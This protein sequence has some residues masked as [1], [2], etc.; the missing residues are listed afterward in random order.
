M[1]P[2]TPAPAADEQTPAPQ[3]DY[4]GRSKQELVDTLAELLQQRPVQALRGEVE[5][6]KVAFYKLHRAEAERA[7]HAFVEAGGAPEEFTPEPDAQETRLKELLADYRKR[8]DEFAATAEQQKEEHLKLKLAIIEE[9]KT[10]IDSHETIGQTWGAFRELQQRWRAVG[11]VP[12]AQNKDLW[13]TYNHH[14]ENFYNLVKIDRE[15]RDLDLRRNYEAKIA[16]CEQ[17]E[18]LLL[19]ASIV[20]AFNKLQKLHEQWREV[21]PVAVEFK[22]TLWERFK[23]ASARVNRR[24]QEHFEQLKGEQK[25]NL[26]LKTQLCVELDELA[27]SPPDTRV[28]WEK[29]SERLL[30]IQQLWKTIGFAPRKENT[31]I[32]E[33]FRAACDKFF[34]QKRR[35]YAEQ[36]GEMD[37]NLALKQQLCIQAEALRESDDW[38]AASDELIA[39][40]KQWK[41]I[42]PVPRRHSD[43]IWKRF[44]AACDAF[45]E[46]KAAHFSVQDGAHAE[47]LRLKEALLAEI[48]AFDGALT[49]D[50][51][52]EFQRRWS[53]IGFVPIKQKDALQAHYK[54][55]MDAMFDQL[56]GAQGERRMD[57]FRE[58]VSTLKSSGGTRLN[59][60]RSRLQAHLKQTEAE[61]QLLEN[62]IGF[63]AKSKNAEAMIREVRAKIER[64]KGEMAAT[65]EKIKL[66]E[67]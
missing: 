2:Q 15:L 8:R 64:A 26:D 14:V 12:L 32:Y 20:A 65:I 63:F 39:L 56:R 11:P 10:L 50:A 36:R 3:N 57:R 60:E 54:Q 62:N 16:L 7:R 66:I 4:A 35:F 55:I 59:S 24:H 29:A 23:E 9:L 30:E 13:E 48:E 19:E 31:A 28:A 38:K 18:A 34:E 47:N 40:Q 52:K 49:F 1:T 22:E 6:I 44:R 25:R 46:R 43:A 61:I 5:A 53:E 41:Q 51:I 37:E 67:N 42:G 33:R 17:A 21:G 58:K 45:F 27:E